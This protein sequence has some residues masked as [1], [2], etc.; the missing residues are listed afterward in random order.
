M[1][2]VN[3]YVSVFDLTGRTVTRTV[4]VDVYPKDYFIGIKSTDYYFGVNENLTFNLVAVN[5]DDKIIKDFKAKAKLVRYEWQ[6][7][8]K[9]DYSGN[10]DDA[11]EQ[12][13]NKM[14]GKRIL[15]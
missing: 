4:S 1:L 11:S 9:K 14:N 5:P 7:V 3:A 10:Y 8:L 12:K 15:L 2:P 13:E 6:T